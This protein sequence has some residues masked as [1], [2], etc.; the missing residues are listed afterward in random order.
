[1]FFDRL[2]ETQVKAAEIN[3]DDDVR[4]ALDRGGAGRAAWQLARYLTFF[5]TSTLPSESSFRLSRP[6]ARPVTV[7]S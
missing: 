7:K 1:M 2:T 5:S 3:A 4:L 6:L